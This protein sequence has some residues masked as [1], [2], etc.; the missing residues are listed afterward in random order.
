VRAS[1][2]LVPTDAGWRVADADTDAGALVGKPHGEL[3]GMRLADLVSLRHIGAALLAIAQATTEDHGFETLDVQHADGGV[4]RVTAT[5]TMRGRGGEPRFDLALVPL[6]AANDLPDLDDLPTR[7]REVV[8]RLARGERVKMI[9]DELY[10]SE[11]TVRN[12]LTA[13]FRKFGVHSQQ[14]LLTL[15]R[16]SGL[17]EP[18]PSPASS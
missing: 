12:H 5:F 2:V 16:R 4:R 10:L 15:L 13:V 18:P 1:V 6:D 11:T 8:I 3:V 9:A 7:Q 17:P 14:E